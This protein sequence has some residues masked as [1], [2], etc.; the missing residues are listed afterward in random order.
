MIPVI[1]GILKAGYA[2]VPVAGELPPERVDTMLEDC[3][4]DLLVSDL[5]IKLNSEVPRAAFE[6]LLSDRSYDGGPPQSY[7]PSGETAFVLYTSGTTGGPKAVPI[8]HESLASYIKAAEKRFGF[9]EKLNVLS[10]ATISFDMF[11]W[12]TVMALASGC[13]LVV[14]DEDEQL[15]ASLLSSLHAVRPFDFILTTPTRFRLLSNDPEGALLLSKMKMLMLGGEQIPRDL[16][17]RLRESTGAKL[18]NLYGPTEIT[19]NATASELGPDGEVNIG[20]PMP[21]YEVYILSPEKRLLPEGIPGEIYVGGPGVASGYPGRPELTAER[22]VELEVHPGIPFYRTGDFGKRL[23]DGN[24]V[25]L[26][27]KDHQIKI[28]GYRM[29]SAEI[30]QYMREIPGMLEV[31]V[32]LRQG[33]H[34][35]VLCACYSSEEEIGSIGY[36]NI[37]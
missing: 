30:E 17:K 20:T 31:K 1:L 2:C 9:N 16:L 23:S 10:I 6:A 13:T 19:F 18:F 14:A 12:E 33:E 22:F 21:N 5:D 36:G 35:D 34:R 24:I 11:V 27:R 26:G 29:E 4:A 8:R 3:A 32:M 7:P 25:F 28:N 37:C 15:R